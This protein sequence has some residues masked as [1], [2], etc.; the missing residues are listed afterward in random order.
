MHDSECSYD[1]SRPKKLL[2]TAYIV[3]LERM[4]DRLKEI[5]GIPI[6]VE[7]TP[8]LLEKYENC[9]TPAPDATRPVR[10]R[11]SQHAATQTSGP[12]APQSPMSRNLLESMV[13][14]TGRLSIDESGN[15]DYS[16]NCA[17]LTLVQ[18]IRER[19][20]VLLDPKAGSRS[21]LTKQSNSQPVTPPARFPSLPHRQP[22]KMSALPT[23][24]AA[25]QYINVALEEACPLFSFIH[26]PS[27]DSRLHVFYAARNAGLDPNLE[28]VRFEAL[29]NSLFALGELFGSGS[30]ISQDGEENRATQA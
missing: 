20:D 5:I 9:P 2:N 13:E 24:D 22:E 25:V 23:W 19:C 15:Y 7:V 18:R 12:D 1:N 16:G 21:R 27:F 14:A 6:E 10:T 30:Y 4:I 17:G 11:P 3:S 8:E 28:D 29:L 26:R